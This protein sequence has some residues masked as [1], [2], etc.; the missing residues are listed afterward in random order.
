MK[1]S[2]RQR[3]GLGPIAGMNEKLQAI[4]VLS[5]REFCCYLVEIASGCHHVAFYYVAMKPNGQ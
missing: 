4:V 2:A 1:D 5:S 3:N